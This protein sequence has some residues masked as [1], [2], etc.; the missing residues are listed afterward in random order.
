M[1]T[2]LI[3]ELAISALEVMLL[4]EDSQASLEQILVYLNGLFVQN[5]TV[6]ELT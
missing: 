3:A 1:L 5:V 2:R 6:S 4:L